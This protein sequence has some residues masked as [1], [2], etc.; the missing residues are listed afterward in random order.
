LEQ[1]L[2]IYDEA[3]GE[4]AERLRSSGL[5][6]TT[7]L[8][9]SGM[10]IEKLR[11]ERHLTL[12]SIRDLAG[13]RIVKRMTLDEQ[14]QMAAL[15]QGLW[16][17]ARLIDRRANPS[18]G[19]RAVHIVPRVRYCPVEIQIRTLYQDGW[20]QTMETLGDH[21]GRAIRYGGDPDEPDTIDKGSTRTRQETVKGWIALGELLHKAAGLENDLARARRKQHTPEQ[22]ARLAELEAQIE[23][24]IGPLRAGIASLSSL[25]SPEGLT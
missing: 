9:T 24:A 8:K 6:P 10:I 2:L 22:A 15:V 13:A 17:G 3:L 21:W 23:Q 16:P 1:L 18:H 25:E 11:R 5:E 4:A 14:D 19:Y 7:R 12:R 20:A